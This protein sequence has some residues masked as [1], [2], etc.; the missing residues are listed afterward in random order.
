MFSLD[1]VLKIDQPDPFRQLE[2]NDFR[3]T[4]ACDFCRLAGSG[5]PRADAPERLRIGRE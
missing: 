2:G 5:A 3:K 1:Q 4:I